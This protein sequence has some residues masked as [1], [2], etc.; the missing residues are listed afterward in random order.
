MIYFCL[1]FSILWLV[2]FIYL[3]TLDRQNRDIAKRLEARTTQS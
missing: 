3:F 2:N 1:A